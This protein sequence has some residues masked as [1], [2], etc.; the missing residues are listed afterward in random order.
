MDRINDGKSISSMISSNVLNPSQRA[1]QMEYC[2]KKASIFLPYIP[3]IEY[4]TFDAMQGNWICAYLSLLPVVEALI[5]E[6]AK[7][8]PTLTFG[9]MKGFGKTLSDYLKNTLNVFEDERIELVNGY[10][11]HLKY[12]L[13]EVLYIDFDTYEDAGFAEIFNRNLTLHKLDGVI[14]VKSG[15]NNVVRTLLLIDIIAELYLM[16]NP[17]RWWEI[18]LAASPENDLD[19]QLRWQLYIKRSMLAIGPDDLLIIQNAL[20]GEATD[21]KKIST[22]KAL[23]AEI[24]FIK[25]LK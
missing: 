20:S 14:N 8:V 22:I 3:V 12:T 13:C 2:F 24:A 23:K 18:T 1:Y 19:F 9:K 7:E 6:W 25:R 17:K 10:L 16:Q 5:R 4:A 11:T 15:L 21:E